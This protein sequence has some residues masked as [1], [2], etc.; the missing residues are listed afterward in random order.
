MAPKSV[1][2]P[3]QGGTGGAGIVVG[4]L[5]NNHVAHFILCHSAFTP[6]WRAKAVHF[7]IS[8]AT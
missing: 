6:A 1:S 4:L 5:A 7:A 8:A 2:G 3:E